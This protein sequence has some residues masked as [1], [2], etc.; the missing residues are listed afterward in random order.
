MAVGVFAAMGIQ[1]VVTT[2]AKTDE[3]ASGYGSIVGVTLGL[4]GGTFFP[5]SQ[6]PGLIQNLS[7]ATPHAWLMRGFGDLSGGAGTIAD[8]LPSLG[9]LLAIGVVT[10]GAAL[11]RSRNLVVR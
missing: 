4:L 7:Y 5:L 10:A 3:Q 6:A 9:A 2:L 11:L 1:S 8:T